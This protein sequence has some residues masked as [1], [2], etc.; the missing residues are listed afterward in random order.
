MQKD[1]YSMALRPTTACRLRR[2]RASAQ[3]G[4]HFKA[5]VGFKLYN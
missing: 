5:N 3:I 4:T 1:S 2:I